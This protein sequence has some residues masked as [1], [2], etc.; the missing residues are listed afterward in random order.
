MEDA[1]RKSGEVGITFVAAAGNEASN[2]DSVARYPT[3]YNLP[4]VISVAAIDDRDALA[5]FSNYGATTV[6]IGGSG[7][8]NLFHAAK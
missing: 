2:N 7:R 4:N 8:F 3:N 6:D 1:I 5:S